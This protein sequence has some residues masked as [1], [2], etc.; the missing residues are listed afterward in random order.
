MGYGKVPV[1][2]GS[3][4][5][6]RQKQTVEW[7]SLN[8]ATF[9]KAGIGRGIGEPFFSVPIEPQKTKTPETGVSGVSMR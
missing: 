2:S 8:K 4:I 6:V 3:P 7:L 1:Y 9:G 5:G